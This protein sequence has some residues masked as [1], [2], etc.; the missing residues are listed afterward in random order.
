M[1]C[2]APDKRNRGSLAAQPLAA[3]GGPIAPEA[4]G[5]SRKLT[6]RLGRIVLPR[7]HPC[8]QPS[9]QSFEFA[10]SWLHNAAL[11]RSKALDRVDSVPTFFASET[12]RE[13]EMPQQDGLSSAA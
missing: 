10:T 11:D 12:E 5:C 7:S 1:T 6:R 9:S 4:V 2:F 13:A 8:P 3:K